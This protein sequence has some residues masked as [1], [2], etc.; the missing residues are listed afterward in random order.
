MDWVF[1]RRLSDWLRTQA[2]RFQTIAKLT[3]SCCTF[4]QKAA[5]TADRK[6]RQAPAAYTKCLGRPVNETDSRYNFQAEVLLQICCRCIDGQL[7]MKFKIAS[8]G[9][10]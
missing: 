5:I 4:R 2:S 9:R 10:P 3:Y 8:R 7:P 1:A 6:D